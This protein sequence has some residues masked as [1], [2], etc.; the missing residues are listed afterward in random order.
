[1]NITQEILVL[2]HLKSNEYITSRIAFDLYGI[3]RLSSVI[4]RLRK[5]GHEI[6]TY[7]KTEKNRYGNYVTFAEYKL[8]KENK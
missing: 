2:N 5:Q 7:A 8:E 3:T 6:I 4:H 1:M